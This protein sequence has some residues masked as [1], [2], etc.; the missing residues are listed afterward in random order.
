MTDGPMRRALTRAGLL[1]L[2]AGYV[3][4]I[5]YTELGGVFAANMTGNSV[6]LAIAAARGE[7]T[8]VIAYGFTLAAFL[9]G[10]VAASGLRR[11]TGRPTVALLAAVALLLVAA[12]GAMGSNARLA[13][14]AA[15]MGLQGGAIARFGATPLQTVVITGTMVRLADHL[16]E[17]LLPAA[18]ASEP[19]AT[20]IH[21]TAWIAYGGGAALAVTAQHFT[22][23]PLLIA[24]LVLVAVTIDVARERPQ[25]TP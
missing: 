14:L 6:L 19:G 23:W 1:C 5:G 25:A 11:T 20:R 16:V 18:K 8:R 9:A 22:R 17:H 2:V 4:A 7:G 12:V 3:D 13:L 15:T 10:A 21:A 24:A